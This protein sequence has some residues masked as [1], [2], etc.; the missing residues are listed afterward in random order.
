MPGV[1]LPQVQDF[2]LLLV[3][4]DKV[5]ASQNLQLVQVQNRILSWK[6]PIRIIMFTSW[7]LTGFT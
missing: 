6:G 4:L 5:P 3:E 7:L 1:V 2:A